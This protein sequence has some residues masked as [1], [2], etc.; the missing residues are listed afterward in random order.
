MAAMFF[1]AEPVS[2]KA[3]SVPSKLILTICSAA[4]PE[5]Y[6][7]GFLLSFRLI[8]LAD[9]FDFFLDNAGAFGY[10]VT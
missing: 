3:T 7:V 2:F 8:V 4:S 5:L 9:S 10:T 6:M 1:A